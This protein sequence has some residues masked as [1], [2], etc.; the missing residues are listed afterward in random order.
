MKKRE[1]VSDPGPCISLKS[2]DLLS[3]WGFSD[4]AAPREWRDFINPP[5]ALGIDYTPFPLIQVVRRYLLPALDQKV[6]V[7]E[8]ATSHNPIRAIS[9]DGVDVVDFWTEGDDSTGIL[10]PE[11]VKVPLPLVELLLP[12]EGEIVTDALSADP[13]SRLN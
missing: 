6:E 1:S 5:E 12:F 10:T 2:A 7:E 4:G 11:F 13:P 3:K 8:I 9:V